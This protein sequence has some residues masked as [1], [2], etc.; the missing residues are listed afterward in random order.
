LTLFELLVALAIFW[1]LLL[2]LAPGLRSFFVR[3]EVRAAVRAVTSGLNAARCAAIRD[4]RAVRVEVAGGD[5]LLSRQSGGGWQ[6][7]RR[8][9]LGDKV[10]VSAN[11]NPVFSPLGFAS[12]LC[13]F[14]VTREK[15]V[16]RIVLSM[17]GRVRVDGSV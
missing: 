16:C 14:T 13:T 1:L 3:L 6:V 15:R 8:F 2:G 7:V 5:L 11:G 10:K 9:E 4:E 17:F 12:P